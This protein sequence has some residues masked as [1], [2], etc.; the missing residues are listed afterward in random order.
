MREKFYKYVDPISNPTIKISS[1]LKNTKI[2]ILLAVLNVSILSLIG[3]IK[4]QN[5]ILEQQQKAKEEISKTI[6][7]GNTKLPKYGSGS[8]NF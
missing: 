4:Y 2:I 8:I 7:N 3:Y 6:G 1:F 5:H